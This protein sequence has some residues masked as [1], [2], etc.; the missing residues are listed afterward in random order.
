MPASRSQRIARRVMS[1]TSRR[2]LPVANTVALFSNDGEWVTGYA[3]GANVISTI[4]IEIQGATQAGI[5]I[6]TDGNRRARATIDPDNFNSGFATW[7]GTSFA[8]PAMAAE[9][10]RRLAK[11]GCPQDIGERRKILDRIL[12]IAPVGDDD[13]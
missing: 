7:S 9:Y 12:P 4:P 11:A 5:L 8:A 6:P 2:L 3:R 13:A 1:P 10:L